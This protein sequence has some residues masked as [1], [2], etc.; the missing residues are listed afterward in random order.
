MGAA[1]SGARR[2]SRRS[3]QHPRGPAEP[4]PPG[5]CHQPGAGLPPRPQVALPAPAARP[6]LQSLRGDQRPRPVRGLGGRRPRT[7]RRS[8][9]RLPGLHGHALPPQARRQHAARPGRAFRFRPVRPGAPR[10]EPARAESVTRSSSSRPARTPASASTAG[11]SARARRP[12]GRGRRDGRSSST[13]LMVQEYVAGR[14]FN[15]GF[16]GAEAMPLSEISFAKMPPG[17]L[18]DRQLRRQVGGGQPGIQGTEPVC[19]APRGARPGRPDRGRGTAG[20]AGA[21]RRGVRPSRH[22]G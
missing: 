3:G 18:A 5:P 14:E 8:L 22:S 17:S 2:T 7:D 15:V 4:A 11:R 1:T 21:G 19:P 9:H 6:G 10:H 20:L 13:E 12:C 16:L